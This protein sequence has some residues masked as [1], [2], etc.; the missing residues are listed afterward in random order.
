MEIRRLSRRWTGLLGFDQPSG[1]D[2]DLA[3]FFFLRICLCFQVTIMCV[4]FVFIFYEHF[5]YCLEI[6]STKIY[7]LVR[8]S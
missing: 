2:A 3:G 7:Q 1:V 6:S 5:I 4:A 8:T